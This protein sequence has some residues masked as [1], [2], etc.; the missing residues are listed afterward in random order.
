MSGA[1]PAG[2]RSAK[3]S[4]GA[5]AGAGGGGAAKRSKSSGRRG[6]D[7]AAG[8]TAA[9]PGVTPAGGFRDANLPAGYAPFNIQR[10]GK[11]LYVT[12]LALDKAGARGACAGV[13]GCGVSVC[14]A[15]PR[16]M[17]CVVSRSRQSIFSR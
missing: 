9:D 1:G 14:S 13:D 10:I 6:G 15:R 7:A 11:R 3:G 4:V 16:V 8:A 5:G 12:G 17:P 2:T